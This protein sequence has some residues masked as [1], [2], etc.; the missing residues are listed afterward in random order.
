MEGRKDELYR[1]AGGIQM[2][3]RP[4]EMNSSLELKCACYRDVTYLVSLTGKPGFDHRSLG[5]HKP[6]FW[7]DLETESYDSE[8]QVLSRSTWRGLP[9]PLWF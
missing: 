1:S 9:L 6:S 7:Q 2:L 4:I 8:K 3:K 5:L